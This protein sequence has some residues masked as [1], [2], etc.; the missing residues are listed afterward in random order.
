VS[1]QRTDK[2]LKRIETKLDIIIGLL[3]DGILAGEEVA[4]MV[5]IDEIVRRKEYQKLAKL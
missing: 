2:T 1:W 3:Q 4:L 5:E